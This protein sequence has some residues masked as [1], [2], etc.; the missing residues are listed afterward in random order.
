MNVLSKSEII[1]FVV[2]EMEHF[3]IIFYYLFNHLY[4]LSPLLSYEFFEGGDPF[5]Y[6]LVSFIEP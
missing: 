5:F 6:L 4:I 2:L 3:N 1:K